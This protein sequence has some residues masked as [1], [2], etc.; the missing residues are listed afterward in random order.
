MDWGAMVV[1]AEEE[2]ASNEEDKG[3]T[4]TGIDVVAGGL[5]MVE[6]SAASGVFDCVENHVWIGG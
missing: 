1:K 3:Q 6:R 4:A 5:T 2:K